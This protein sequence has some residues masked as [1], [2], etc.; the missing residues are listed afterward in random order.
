MIA[1]IANTFRRLRGDQ[2]GN[3]LLMAG[4][5]LTGLVGAAGIGV[6]TVQWY[7]WKRQMQ[8][9]VDTGATAGA[10]AMARG[11]SSSTAVNREVARTA[12]TSYSIEAINTPPTSGAYSGNSGAIEVYATTSQTLPF[13]S[14]FLSTAPT[15]R[16]RA[17]AT[18]V[19]VGNPCVI[20][21]ATSGTGVEVF[22]GAQV[23]LGCPVASNSPGGVSVDVGG[24]SYL[25]TDMV[26]SVGGIDYG[27]GNLPSDASIVSYGLPVD[28]PLASRNLSFSSSGCTYN[29]YHVNP[30]EYATPS[31]GTYCNGMQLQGTV[32]LHGGVYIIKGGTLQINSSADVGLYG[33]GGVTFILTGTSSSTVATVSINGSATVNLTAPTSTQNSTFAGVLFYQDPIGEASHTING[34]ANINLEGI[35]YMPTG[36]LTYNGDSTQ[37]AQC[38]L[39]VTERIRFGGTNNIENNCNTDVDAWA[40]TARVIRVVE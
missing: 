20:A 6:D 36:D 39:I 37:S 29:H 4:A 14:V 24:S 13:S 25:D 5:A 17:V 31:A 15:I 1:R 18:S 16:V 27:T 21:T 12:N 7:M 10:I 23:N 26:M 38:L 35:I 9:A 8:Q 34:G 19:A 11:L 22:G 2:R 30:N 33:D 40:G 32:R 28:D 3:I